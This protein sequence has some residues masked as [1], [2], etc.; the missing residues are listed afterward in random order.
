MATVRLTGTDWV[1]LDPAGTHQLRFA[2]AD[3]KVVGAALRHIVVGTK[4]SDR[5]WCEIGLVQWEPWYGYRPLFTVTSEPGKPI[6]LSPHIV[7]EI[8]GDKGFIRD[9]IWLSSEAEVD[10]ASMSVLEAQNHVSGT[11][12]GEPFSGAEDDL[13]DIAIRRDLGDKV[14]EEEADAD[15]KLYDLFESSAV[16]P[17]VQ[18][19]IDEGQELHDAFQEAVVSEQRESLRKDLLDEVAGMILGDRNISYGPPHIDFQRTA[20]MVSAMWA[21]KLGEGVR[22]EAHE[23]AQF[24]ICVKL[25]RLQW[26]PQ[27]RD[28]WADGVGYFACGF[29]AYELTHDTGEDNG[30][31]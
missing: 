18:S 15:H 28:N 27:K 30:N 2:K 25:S 24:L 3:G 7:C 23:V 1:N 5:V 17:E 12:D 6:S 19:R 14:P 22:I 16:D 8:C 21:H 31:D 9:G 11:Q 4:W 13:Y 29:E 26:S 10:T 20:D